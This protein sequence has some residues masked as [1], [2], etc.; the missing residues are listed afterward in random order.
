[1]GSEGEN[2]QVGNDRVIKEY[3]RKQ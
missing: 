2:Y 3:G 1:M